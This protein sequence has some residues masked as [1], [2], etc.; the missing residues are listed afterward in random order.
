M[1]EHGEIS[2]RFSGSGDIHGIVSRGL[3]RSQVAK[4][5]SERGVAKE[6]R[7][8]AALHRAQHAVP[9]RSG[10]PVGLWVGGVWLETGP[11]GDHGRGGFTQ[12][13]S[14][15]DCSPY[16]SAPILNLIFIVTMIGISEAE[17][18]DLNVVSISNC[19]HPMYARCC[20]CR[21][22]EKSRRDAL[23]LRSGQAGTTKDKGA[24]RKASPLKR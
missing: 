17:G 16:C 20:Q 9:L 22:T 18:K 14:R 2:T 5:G 21:R 13:C 24:M 12:Q 11:R 15:G 8:S 4:A 3:N 6:W 19:S 23:R 10:W 1:P 7:W